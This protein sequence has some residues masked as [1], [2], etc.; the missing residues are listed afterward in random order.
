V[1][2]KKIQVNCFR[3]LYD[4][5]ILLEERTTIVVGRNNS[6]KTSLTEV[7]SRF[8]ADGNSTFNLEDFSC[9]SHHLF[10]DAYQKKL[11][12]ATHAE[13]RKLLPSITLALEFEYAADDQFGTLQDFIIDLDPNCTTAKVVLSYEIEEG[14]IERLFD[15]M[16]DPSEDTKLEFFRT[17]RERIPRLY[18]T[19]IFAVD[20]NDATNLRSISKAGLRAACMNNRISAQRGLDDDSSKERVVIG[21]VL[22]NLFATA[23]SDSFDTAGHTLAEDLERAVMEIQRKFGADFNEKLNELLPALSLFGYP[24]LN[25]PNLRTETTFD[26]ERLLTNHTKV[27]YTGSSGVPLPESHNGLGARS[28]ILILLQLR[29]HF[30]LFCAAEPKPAAQLIF[31]E[32]PEVHLHPQMQEVFV[33]KLSE[34]SSAFSNEIS[35]TWPV[36]FVLSTHSSHLANEAHFESIRYFLST[37][38][39]GTT[40]SKAIVKDLREGLSEKTDP[41]RSFL[42]Q[43]MT[44][45]RCD[46]FFAD[47]A[48]LIEG[49]TERLLLPRMIRIIDSARLDGPM[50]A[51]QYVSIIE[52]GGAYAHLFFDLLR[53]LE[54]RTLII[55]DIDTVAPDGSK[56]GHK[57]CPVRKGVRT[58]NACINSWFSN[59]ANS[60]YKPTPTELLRAG[61][62]QK[63]SGRMRIAYQLPETDGGPCGRSFEDAFMLANAEHSG[64]TTKQ[65]QDERADEAYEAAKEVKKSEFALTY[66]LTKSDWIVPRYIREGLNWLATDEPVE[67]LPEVQNA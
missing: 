35:A 20:P 15:G 54:I 64:L 4:I 63:I 22:E 46:L 53:F 43:Y 30:K 40:E 50:L 61:E 52:V 21:K 44:L 62:K 18:A 34:I 27:R 55:T 57:A 28:I 25:D 7:V 49:T 37:P 58:S 24:G 14:K 9:A 5:A 31:I 45:T 65:T 26:V 23:K 66:A 32:E 59:P 60:A 10:W 6:G 19:S 47:K 38:R 13:L 17:I 29:E 33:R 16:T 48:I 3:L 67:L 36:Q 1:R 8:L 56:N 41:D 51:S 12:G 11:E 39:D 2:L 42:Y